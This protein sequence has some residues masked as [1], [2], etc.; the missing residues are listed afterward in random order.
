MRLAIG[1][2]T[3]IFFFLFHVAFLLFCL[4]FRV[5]G[6]VYGNAWA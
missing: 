2:A 1:L 3:Y 4:W 6:G 5:V